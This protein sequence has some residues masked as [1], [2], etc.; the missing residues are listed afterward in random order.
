IQQLLGDPLATNLDEL[1]DDPYTVNIRLPATVAPA[2]RETNPVSLPPLRETNPVSLP[3]VHEVTHPHAAPISDPAI[4]AE[5]D[6][7]GQTVIADPDEVRRAVAQRDG[8]PE[9]T[10]SAESVMS[11]VTPE[12]KAPRDVT[13]DAM[14]VR[15]GRG[16]Q[17]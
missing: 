15:R 1:L 2:A 13:A 7:S 16:R 10:V 17:L 3:P 5:S 4:S 8:M 11:E 14:P 12:Q 6:P 9:R